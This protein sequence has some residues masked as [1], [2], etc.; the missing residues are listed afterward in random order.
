MNEDFAGLRDEMIRTIDE[1]STVEAVPECPC[2]DLRR[3]LMENRFN[4]VVVGQFKRGKTTFINALLG[5]DLLP[6]AVVPLTS[7]VTVIEYGDSVTIKVFLNN[8]ENKEIPLEELPLYVTESGNPRNKRDVAEVSIQYPSPYLRE[9]VRLIDTPGVGSVYQ[10]NTDVAYEY[11]PRSDAAVFL[12]SVDQPLSKAELD[13]LKD[14]K[15]YSDR[16]FFIQNKA[17]YL[18]PEDLKESLAFT[19]R[20]LQDEAGYETIE[21]YPLSARLG[22]EGKL[23]RDPAALEASRLTV[24]EERLHRFLVEEKGG[25]LIRSAAKNLLKVLSEAI[26]RAE[27]EYKSMN[28]PLELI[29]KK[30][31]TFEEKQREIEADKN[32]F[33][34]LL[35]GETKRIIEKILD[36]DLNAAKKDLAQGLGPAFEDFYAR[37]RSLSPGKLRKALEEFVVHQVKEY[38]TVFRKNE[39]TKI[40]MAF[41]KGCER[42]VTRIN[43]IIDALLHYASDLFSVGFETFDAESLW[44]MKSSFYFIFKDEPIMVE[45]LGN[46]LTTM[47]PRFLSH[48]IIARS[49]RRYLAAMIEQQSGRI[50]WDFVERLQKSKLEVR[51]VMFAKIDETIQEIRNAVQRGIARKEK[52]KEEAAKRETEIRT[53]LDHLY[54]LKERALRI[55][56]RS[57]RHPDPH[58]LG[59]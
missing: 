34:I 51:W 55:L 31:D 28:T 9:G 30:L 11:L 1:V 38:D 41:E 23:N 49:M 32:D 2:S 53:D 35:E 5:A 6:T 42:F 43:E 58:H 48:P 7:I 13:F 12:I 18:T 29:Q 54:A 21:V 19:G 47:M 52:G 33:E 59:S 46:A 44:T 8:G 17:D 27:L 25:I 14:V 40:S 57:G 36:P 4:L 3:K 56:D 20:V 45:I 15:Q 26:L 24:F 22:L 37:N 10:H 16:I 39:D 50:R